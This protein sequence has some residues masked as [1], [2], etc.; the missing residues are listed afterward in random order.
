M[1]LSSKGALFIAGM[2]GCVLHPYDDPAGYATIGIGHLLHKSRVTMADKLKWRG[3]KQKDHWPVMLFLHGDGERG[4]A[5]AELDYV[6]IHGPLSEA[7]FQ[8][9][10]LPFVIISPQLDKFS[11]GDIP[12]IRDRTPAQIPK[13]QANGAPPRQDERKPE[14]LPA[15]DDLA[16]APLGPPEGWS[17]MDAEVMAMVDNTLRDYKGDPKRV[18]ITGLS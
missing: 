4:D 5:K 7:W 14:G 12:Y 18:Y 10:D 8:K 17:E 1:R 9:R 13:R 6:L 2:E 16:N 15:D 3:F 11:R